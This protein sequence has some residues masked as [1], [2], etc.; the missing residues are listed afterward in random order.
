ML[1]ATYCSHGVSSGLF[2]HY[3]VGGSR[4]GKPQTTVCLLGEPGGGRDRDGW[5]RCST[6]S[7]PETECPY[8]KDFHRK[9][10]VSG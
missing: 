2:A 4:Q 10:L 6:V 9:T 8:F 5:P 3:Q 7:Y 1:A